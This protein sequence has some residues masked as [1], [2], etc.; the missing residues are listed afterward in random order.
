[1]NPTPERNRQILNLRK[2]GFSQRE[3]AEKFRLSKSRIYLLERSQ[4]AELA[5]AEQRAAILKEMR[6]ADDPER[7]WPVH[8]VADALGVGRVVRKSLLNHLASAGRDRLSLRELMEMCLNAP[9]PRLKIS[10]PPLL[11]IRCIGRKGFWS[12]VNAL[13]NANLGDRCNEE[14]RIRLD[15]V[16]RECER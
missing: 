10:W 14:W 13:T 12:V 6:A 1:M 5:A 11:R 9:D 7:L 16:K 2:E 4:R 15:Q 8:D 3:V